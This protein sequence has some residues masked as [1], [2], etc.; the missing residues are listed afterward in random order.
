M[1]KMA[2][3]AQSRLL[4]LVLLG[5]SSST[6]TTTGT[7]AASTSDLP[8]IVIVLADDLDMTLGGWKAST[9]SKTR[10]LIGNHGMVIENWFA[11]T[12]VCCP[13]RA[14][15]LTG[16]YF[17]NLWANQENATGGCMHVNVTDSST[18]EFYATNYFAQYFQKQNYTVGLFG[19]HLNNANPTKF[20][21]EGVD[22]MLINGG[23]QYINPDFTYGVRNSDNPPSNVHFNNCTSYDCYT[24]SIVGNASLA[25]IQRHL[26]LDNNENNDDQ[27]RQ[28]T[29]SSQ[30][31]KPFF[32]LISVKA[33]HLQDGEGFPI[34]TPAPWYKDVD[35]IEKYA[36]RTLNYN[37]SCPD[38]HWLVRQQQPLTDEQGQHIDELYQSR[39]RT[40][41]SVDDL[42]EDLVQT[43][44]KYRVLDNTYIVFTSDNGY[45]LG[46]FRMGTC[47][48]HAYENDIRVPM[49]I[50]GPGIQSFSVRDDI[51]GTHTDLMPTLLGLVHHKSVSTSHKDGTD[52]NDV[53]EDDVVPETMDGRNLGSQLLQPNPIQ[54]PKKRTLLIEYKSLG[55]VVRYEHLVDTYN[56]TF[57]ALRIFDETL[58]DPKYH[59][60]KYI[61]YRDS[62]Q[63]WNSTKPPLEEE[64][65]D[66]NLDP[67]E[68]KNLIVGDGSE[69]FGEY[70]VR[71]SS[72]FRHGLSTMIS[73]MIQCQ[74]KA[75]REQ[76]ND[77]SRY[78]VELVHQTMG[79]TTYTTTSM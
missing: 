63:D 30:K 71:S 52:Y 3:V 14:E 32:S 74:G 79:T 15:L 45:R 42:V 11:Q 47:K 78:Y 51:I 18:N 13:S 21:P 48:L 72:L 39:L 58:P 70:D 43:L 10:A 29:P 54:R 38:H 65:F 26:S 24:T 36:P 6:T 49:M 61:Q 69:T 62:R 1:R 22:T 17:H 44:E 67:Y 59:N 66:L 7:T 50:R 40:L 73:S 8:N 19:K 25:W 56:H 53:E 28:E 23:G 4:L 9:L 41:L 35:V 34:S 37:A 77:L 64:L 27:Q 55:S 12:P 20:I 76:E 16:K 2:V 75:C 46:Q 60:L 57:I 5:V 68:M 33:P 31:K